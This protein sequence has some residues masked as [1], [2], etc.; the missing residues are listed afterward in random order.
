TGQNG[1][2][3]VRNWTDST[4]RFHTLGALVDGNQS[5]VRIKKQTT[6]TIIT[7]SRERLSA[8][9]RAF[10]AKA[11][12]P[13]RQPDRSQPRGR[14]AEQT[15]K[16]PEESAKSPLGWLKD[17]AASSPLVAGPS[18]ARGR[19]ASADAA[20]STSPGRADNGARLPENMVYVRLSK[21]LLQRMVR[22]DI[23]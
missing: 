5:S 20:S 19:R 4:G 2:P 12:E 11:L 9:D 15:N 14:T 3:A 13:A 10:V 8:Q 22:Q 17:L 1:L 16:A 6:G 23:S 7:V 18:D 21:P